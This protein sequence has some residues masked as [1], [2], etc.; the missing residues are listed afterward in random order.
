[1]KINGL[2]T[3]ASAIRSM[4]RQG[5]FCTYQQAKDAG[6]LDSLTVPGLSCNMTTRDRVTMIVNHGGRR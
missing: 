6:A 1:M 5:V 3:K 4:I 2:M